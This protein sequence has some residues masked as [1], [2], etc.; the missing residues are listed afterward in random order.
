MKKTICVILIVCVIAALFSLHKDTDKSSIFRLH[1]IANSN[2]ESDQSVK[3]LVRDAILDV[4]RQLF[5]EKAVEDAKDARNLL[6]QNAK[7][8]HTAAQERLSENGKAYSVKLSVGTYAF[9][10]KTYGDTTYPAG[11]YNALRVVLGDGK[12]ENWWCVMFPPL[13][14][15]N[16]TGAKNYD[17]TA[18]TPVEFKSIF[19]GLGKWFKDLFNIG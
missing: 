18:D 9:P 15:T 3:L 1:I 4:E 7:M 19:G 12:G 5:S 17:N 16:D 13:C 8:L 11:D 6:M 14:I 2:S 10:D